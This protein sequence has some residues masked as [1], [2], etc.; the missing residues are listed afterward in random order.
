VI[1]PLIL[2]SLGLC[3]C[4]GSDAPNPLVSGGGSGARA[5]G[6]SGSAASTTEMA[7][8]SAGA[9]GAA[10]AAGAA[11]NEGSKSRP[12]AGSKESHH[13]L[14]P[15][16]SWTYHH[17]NPNKPAW[18]EVD[19]VEASTYMDKEAFASTDEEDVEGASTTSLLVVDGTA[20]YRAYREVSISGKVALKV[21]YEPRF[22]RYDEA[23]ETVGQTVTL[24]D[25]WTQTCVFSSSASQCAPGAV[26]AGTTTH[27][28]TVLQTSVSVTVP[29]GTFDAVEIERVN[30][31]ANETKHF[32]FAVGVGKIR[33]EDVTSGAIEE[34]S[35]Y[36]VP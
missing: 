33:E 9:V 12:Q 13:P 21:A 23:W 16:S 6:R 1:R 10:G 2:L 7:G 5:A 19:T 26:K 4:V 29:A 35:A 8:A 3:A 28:Y 24:D 27:K 34:L 18:D 15:G 20:V 22:L 11:G 32:W 30:P 25:K 17:T 14:V 36:H 31:S